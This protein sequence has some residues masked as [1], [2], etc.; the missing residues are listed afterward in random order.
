MNVYRILLKYPSGQSLFRA[1]ATVFAVILATLI[2]LVTVSLGQGWMARD[3]K[4]SLVSNLF[5]TTTSTPADSVKDP[6]YLSTYDSEFNS[7]PIKE[8]GIHKTVQSEVLP[9]GLTTTPGNNEL[10]VTPGLKNLIDTNPT[11]VERYARYDIKASFPSELAPSPDSLM[12]LYQIREEAIHAENSQL[13]VSSSEEL[14]SRYN[15]QAAQNKNDTTTRLTVPLLA[16]VIIITPV[17]LLIAEIARI[18]IVQREKRYA[19][20]SLAGATKM[21][22]R[23]LVAMETLP[24]SLLGS[25]LGVVIFIFVGIPILA[26]TPLGDSTIWLAD[27]NLSSLVYLIIG[28]AVVVCSVLAGLQSVSPVK[29]SPLAVTRTLGD[30]KKP[31]FLSILPLLFGVAGLWML[32]AFGGSWYKDNPE[33]GTYVIIG[34]VLAIIVGIFIAG[35]YLTRSLSSLLLRVPRGASMTMAAHRIRSVSRKEFHS[36]SGIIL[37]LFVGSLLMTML[38]TIQATGMKYQATQTSASEDLNPLQNPLQVTVLLPPTGSDQLIEDFEHD[39]EI[40]NLTSSRYIQKSFR[41]NS[42]TRD[43]SATPIM[44]SYYESCAIFQQ[45]TGLSCDKNIKADSPFVVTLQLIQTA[46]SNLGKLEPQFTSVSSVAGT[47]TND[48]Y[49]LVAKDHQSRDR[50]VNEVYNIASTY[51]LKSGDKVSIDYV[52][53]NDISPIA[54]IE[55]LERLIVIIL[56]I[57]MMTGG[58]SLFANIAG[59]IF[60]RKRTFI[61]LR[62]V[63]ASIG[64]LARSLSIEVLAPLCALSILVVSLGIFSCYC[65]LSTIGAFDDGRIVFSLPNTA[66]WVG[67]VA[68]IILSVIVSLLNIPILSKMINFDEMRSE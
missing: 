29:I 32:S 15:R 30:I 44:G 13:Q 51:H 10:W 23:L 36:I 35:P 9:G 12:L 53:P 21:Q 11:L 60:E 16:G 47:I 14:W 40:G 26:N 55:G 39:I 62:A 22:I 18:G 68:T 25:I 34:L 3:Q 8:I 59:G 5:P 61:R 2:I 19:A 24:L 64:A 67:L 56:V 27:L 66:L 54:A 42:D 38:A 57:A 17:L 1:I 41:E 63:G 6:I 45:R 4:A 49:V 46:G 28:V 20:L 33:F 48:S 65:L 43:E 52:R 37:A 7:L 58:L 50:L 31:S